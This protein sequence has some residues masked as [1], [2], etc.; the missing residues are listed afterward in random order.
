[1]P[2]PHGSKIVV[3]IHNLWLLATLLT[4]AILIPFIILVAL[5]RER[6]FL[7]V[8]LRPRAIGGDHADV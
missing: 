8:T 2:S 4:P 1:L 5:V 3:F 7:D 6:G